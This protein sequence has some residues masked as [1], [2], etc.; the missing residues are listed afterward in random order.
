MADEQP[1]KQYEYGLTPEMEGEG[2]ASLFTNLVGAFTPLRSEVIHPRETRFVDVDGAGI[3]EVIPGEYKEPEFGMRHM[4]VRRAVSKG[5]DYFSDFFT[6]PE[7]RATAAQTL[8]GIPGALLKQQVLGSEALMQGYPS[9]YDPETGEE[10]TFDPL[11][12][13]AMAAPAGILLRPSGTFVGMFAGMKSPMA[14]VDALKTAKN[15]EKARIS[16]AKIW[17]DTGWWNDK[18]DWKF[19]ISDEAAR[20]RDASLAPIIMERV[21]ELKSDPEAVA[22]W[23]KL[24]PRKPDGK[25]YTLDDVLDHP[26][27]MKLYPEVEGFDY[28]KRGWL[29]HGRRYAKDTRR[30]QRELA[31]LQEVQSNPGAIAKYKGRSLGGQPPGWADQD[32]WHSGE[33]EAAIEDRSEFLKE[34][35]AGREQRVSEY[36]SQPTHGA[37]GD[38]PVTSG[39][40]SPDSTGEYSVRDDRIA[41]STSLRKSAPPITPEIRAKLARYKELESMDIWDEDPSTWVSKGIPTKKIIEFQ[42]EYQRLKKEVRPWLGRK[43]Q[44]YDDYT[45][46]LLHELQHAIQS[47]EGWAMGGAPSEAK[48]GKL[49]KFYVKEL[50]KILQNKKRFPLDEYFRVLETNDIKKVVTNFRNTHPEAYKL[51]ADEAAT[52]VYYRFAGEAEARN[53]EYRRNFSDATRRRIPPWETLKEVSKVPE[54]E[55]I[56]IKKA[57]GGFIDKPLYDR[58]L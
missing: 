57:A 12:V 11:L 48:T 10:F 15:M 26:E 30:L 22:R 6:N 2:L 28:Q 46:T 47:R 45:D 29:A 8:A 3:K 19:E 31:Q 52:K 1:Q 42:N 43:T 40:R 23:L 14:D 49:R 4:P 38:V 5:L 17:Q 18:G 56:I 39:V 16:R 37:I 44:G 54:E 20:A 13:P 21:E 34:L 51:I 32:R 35:L 58:S 7:T 9:G 27:L 55:L 36:V 53:V 33:L 25:Q 41:L 50:H 24:L